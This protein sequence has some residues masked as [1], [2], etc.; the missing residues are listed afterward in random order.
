MDLLTKIATKR[1]VGKLC[2]Q[3]RY[4]GQRDDSHPKWDKQDDERF[5]HALQNGVRFGI[6]ELFISAFSI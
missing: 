4:T 2:M 5:H 3:C 1:L 6:Y